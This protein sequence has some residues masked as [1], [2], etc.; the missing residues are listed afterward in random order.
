MTTTGIWMYRE[1]LVGSVIG[2]EGAAAATIAV[3]DVVCRSIG[4]ALGLL[5]DDEALA[6]T[7]RR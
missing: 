3:A 6:A 5:L 4:D 2:S 7:L 1:T